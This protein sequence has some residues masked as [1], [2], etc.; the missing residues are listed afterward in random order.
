MLNHMPEFL[1]MFIFWEDVDAVIK[2]YK[3]GNGLVQAKSIKG[4]PS[5]LKVRFYNK[6][7]ISCS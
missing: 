7:V 6:Q 1:E 4:F 3:H 5:L 2:P